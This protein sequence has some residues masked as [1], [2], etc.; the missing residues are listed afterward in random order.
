MS[1]AAAIEQLPSDTIVRGAVLRRWVD[2]AADSLTEQIGAAW[3]T[4]EDELGSARYVILRRKA[5]QAAP[6]VLVA[7]DDS[8]GIDVLAADDTS[9]SEIDALLSELEVPSVSGSSRA[10]A[11]LMDAVR[12]LEDGVRELEEAR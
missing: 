10:P 6:M 9:D 12:A 11:S 1:V 8:P 7:Y 2:A 3:A 5:A 4:G